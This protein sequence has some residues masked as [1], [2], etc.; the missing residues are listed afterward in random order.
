MP[1]AMIDRNVRRIAERP[2]DGC[3]ARGSKFLYERACVRNYTAWIAPDEPAGTDITSPARGELDAGHAAAFGDGGGNSA[4]HGFAR[5]RRRRIITAVAAW[6]RDISDDGAIK[7][8]GRAL[9][10]EF[11]V[12]AVG[13]SIRDIT[14][15]HT[16]EEYPFTARVDD[17]VRHCD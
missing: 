9:P 3:A 6:Y 5:K 10:V 8:A 7:G 2:D 14:R 4:P 1:K 13:Q 11:D 15:V 16:Q 12:A 17:S